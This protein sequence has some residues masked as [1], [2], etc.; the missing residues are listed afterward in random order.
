MRSRAAFDLGVVIGVAL[1]ARVLFLA[2]M[3]PDAVS[4]D[5]RGWLAVGLVFDHGGN[6]Y[7]ETDLIA[8]LPL[9][10][11]ILYALNRGAHATGIPLHLLIRGFLIACEVVTMAV[12]YFLVRKHTARPRELLLAGASL[13]PVAILLVCQHANFDA[14]MM[15]WVVLALAALAAFRASGNPVEWLAACLL[16][17]VAIL[18]KTVP[19]VLTP[20]LALGIAR[21]DGRTRAL[22]GALALGP[23]LLGLSAIYVLAPAAVEGDVIQYRS[24]PGWFG[25]SGILSLLGKEATLG[26]YTSLFLGWLAATSAAAAWLLWSGERT[27]DSLLCMLALLLVAA[28]PALGPGYGPQYLAWLVPLF[29]LVYAVLPAWRPFV[30][31]FYAVAAATCLFE[32]ALV[33]SHGAFLVKLVRTPEMTAAGERW[34]EQGRVV[35][36]RLPLFLAFLALLGFGWREVLVRG[37]RATSTQSSPSGA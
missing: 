4:L 20:L 23:A 28:V 36:F 6:P 13:N 11:Q 27:G 29:V 17:G 12:L 24:V 19:L 16:L 34:S 30:L 14:L 10:P 35:L 31:L 7:V 15:L 8:Y 37:R 21:L 5:L 1:I 33:E 3:P 2:L 9:W 22:G 18:A 25:V 32:Y 26:P